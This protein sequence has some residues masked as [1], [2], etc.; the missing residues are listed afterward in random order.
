MQR[1]RRGQRMDN[2]SA[3][4]ESVGP[5]FWDLDTRLGVQLSK[6]PALRGVVTVCTDIS[7]KVFGQELDNRE[8]TGWIIMWSSCWSPCGPGG[9]QGLMTEPAL[10]LWHSQ[11]QVSGSISTPAPNTV[12]GCSAVH[13]HPKSFALLCLLFICSDII[14]RLSSRKAFSLFLFGFSFN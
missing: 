4:C 5:S 1:S 2:F 8:Q 3:K 12:P 10:L 11:R 9:T 7:T 13:I 6:N 14:S